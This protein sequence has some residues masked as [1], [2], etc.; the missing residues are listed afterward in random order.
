MFKF[1]S[2]WN[3]FTFVRYFIIMTLLIYD[4]V[5]WIIEKLKLRIIA[6]HQRLRYSYL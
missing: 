4:L 1:I 6:K 3:I 5:K 2:L